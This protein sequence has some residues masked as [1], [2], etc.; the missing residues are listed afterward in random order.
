MYKYFQSWWRIPSIPST[1]ASSSGTRLRLAFPRM[2]R[3]DFNLLILVPGKHCTK[4]LDVLGSHLVP[5]SQGVSC[6]RNGSKVLLQASPTLAQSDFFYMRINNCPLNSPARPSYFGH[7]KNL[8]SDMI[9]FSVKVSMI[10]ANEF[11]LHLPYMSALFHSLPKSGQPPSVLEP[12]AKP[13]LDYGCSLVET[14]D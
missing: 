11:Y 2:R 1:V 5:P 8:M 13:S 6:H 7:S 3:S 9:D 10:L 4:L 12:H 14:F